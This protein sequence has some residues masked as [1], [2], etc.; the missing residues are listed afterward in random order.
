MPKDGGISQETCDA[1]ARNSGY[2]RQAIERVAREAKLIGR[3]KDADLSVPIIPCES[4]KAAA[5]GQ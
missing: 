2:R 5:T 3:M 4:S 1:P